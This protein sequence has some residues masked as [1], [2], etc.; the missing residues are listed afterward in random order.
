MTPWNHSELL[1][2]TEQEVRQFRGTQW[3]SLERP[4][5]G[6]CCDLLAHSPSFLFHPGVLAWPRVMCRT[7]CLVNKHSPFSV[8]RWLF[9]QWRLSKHMLKQNISTLGRHPKSNYKCCIWLLEKHRKFYSKKLEKVVLWISLGKW[10]SYGSVII[11]Q[12]RFQ[13]K[14]CIL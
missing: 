4:P 5:Q 2:S 1:G 8:I 10:G 3:S 12:N 6:C 14:V 7:L 13:G 11:R 9:Y